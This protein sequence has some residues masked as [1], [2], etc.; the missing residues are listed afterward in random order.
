MEKSVNFLLNKKEKDQSSNKTNVM[1]ES[2]SQKVTETT[3]DLLISLANEPSLAYF[4]I[5]EHIRKSV[6]EILKYQ[7][8][9]EHLDSQLRGSCYDL[10]YAL[11]NVRSISKAT[12]HFNRINELLKSSLFAKLQLDYARMNALS[13]K[14]PQK[15]RPTQCNQDVHTDVSFQNKCTEIPTNSRTLSHISS[16]VSTAAVQVRDQAINL[17]RRVL[18]TQSAD[19]SY[20]IM[21]PISSDSKIT[22]SSSSFDEKPKFLEA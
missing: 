14:E 13:H 19:V 17:T 8:K 16:T 9:V 6:P 10:D 7:L 18:W 12:V 1:N 11:D 3:S 15:R 21:S 4:H 5:Q 2:L 22:N 20:S